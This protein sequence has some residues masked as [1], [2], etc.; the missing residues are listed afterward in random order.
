MEQIKIRL[1]AAADIPIIAAAFTELGWQKPAS[2]VAREKKWSFPYQG[3]GYAW[4]ETMSGTCGSDL[5]AEW[6]VREVKKCRQHAFP[7]FGFGYAYP[8][9]ARLTLRL[10]E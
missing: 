6:Q 5:V 4:T 9:K 3:Y 1:L 7:Y 2:Q 8:L 10:V